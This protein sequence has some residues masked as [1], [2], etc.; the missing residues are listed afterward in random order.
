MN[1]FHNRKGGNFAVECVSNYIIVQKSFSTLTVRF[2]TDK[3]KI[4]EKLEN[5]TKKEGIF[6]KKAFIAVKNIF[7]KKRK[8]QKYVVVGRLLAISKKWLL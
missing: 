2:F 4:L 5:T 6:Q 7:T 3:T 8:R 1:S